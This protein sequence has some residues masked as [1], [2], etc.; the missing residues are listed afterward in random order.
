MKKLFMIK[1]KIFRLYNKRFLLLIIAALLLL[2][3]FTLFTGCTGL[4][5]YTYEEYKKIKALNENKEVVNDDQGQSDLESF[6]KDLDLHNNYIKDFKLVYNKYSDLLLPMFNSFDNEQEDLD[7]KNQYAE[8]IIIYQN[9]WL[10]D[11]NEI[12][13]PDIMLTYHKYFQEYLEKEVLF[14]ESFLKGEAEILDKHQ[15]EANEASENTKK[16]LQNIE[17]DFNS[18]AEELGIEQPFE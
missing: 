8:S 18:R 10:K 6:Y 7:K 11:I 3:S 1:S 15:L 17:Q 12:D 4:P 16:E 9:D 2:I 5:K 14:Y 13:V